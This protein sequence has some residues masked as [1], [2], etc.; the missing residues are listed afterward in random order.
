MLVGYSKC[1]VKKK[2]K[3]NTRRIPIITLLYSLKLHHEKRPLSMKTDNIK[4][5]QRCDNG[6]SV[7]ANK[8]SSTSS[9]TS[10]VSKKKNHRV[11]EEPL[12]TTVTFDTKYQY[13][14]DVIPATSS[15][16]S[17]SLSDNYSPFGQF[18]LTLTHQPI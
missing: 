3:K 4:K 6:S 2:K 16:S 18:G 10:N 9:T 12:T 17:S 5:R 8:V 1:F 14:E 7:N 11:M 15:S 13:M